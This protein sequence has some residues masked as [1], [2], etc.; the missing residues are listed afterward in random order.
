MRYYENAHSLHHL[1]DP[2]RNTRIPI[3]CTYIKVYKLT[4][5]CPMQNCDEIV[6]LLINGM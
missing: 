2:G 5:V 1:K 3:L 6:G 4:D